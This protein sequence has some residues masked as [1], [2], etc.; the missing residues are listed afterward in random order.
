MF[1]GQLALNKS[2]SCNFWSFHEFCRTSPPPTPYHIY[3]PKLKKNGSFNFNYAPWHRNLKQY[4]CLKFLLPFVVGTTTGSTTVSGLGGRGGRGGRGSFVELTGGDI[5]LY[6]LILYRSFPSSNNSR[7]SPSPLALTQTKQKATKISVLK[8][9]IFILEALKE[10]KKN[11][12]DMHRGFSLNLFKT[13]N[14][15]TLG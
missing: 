6:P 12:V 2:F 3:L 13:T 1:S 5:R 10:K 4:V 9:R 11:R 7:L 14:F 15:R 8:N